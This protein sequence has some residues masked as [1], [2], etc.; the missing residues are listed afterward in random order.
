MHIALG[1]ALGE[2]AKRIEGMITTGGTYVVVG[3]V[4]VLAATVAVRKHRKRALALASV[5]TPGDADPELEP[6]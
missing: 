4:L 1:A 6:A 2:A 5:V 3:L